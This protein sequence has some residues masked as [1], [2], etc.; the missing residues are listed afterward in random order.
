MVAPKPIVR[1]WISNYGTSGAPDVSMDVKAGE[2]LVVASWNYSTS[3]KAIQ[4][5]TLTGAS[6]SWNVAGT[7]SSCSFSAQFVAEDKTITLG[8][9]A[10]TCTAGVWGTLQI[11]VAFSN[12]THAMHYW[13]DAPYKNPD[14]SSSQP[15]SGGRPMDW[16]SS[17]SSV[18][19]AA[20]GH[21]TM[22]VFAANIWS[23]QT[24]TGAPTFTPD[25]V[26]SL[27]EADWL[28]SWRHTTGAVGYYD[29]TA[30]D[31]SPYGA[32]ANGTASLCPGIALPVFTVEAEEDDPV[33][34]GV[35][36]VDTA[37]SATS[38]DV[39]SV[40]VEAGDWCV[41][42][43][44]C[45]YGSQADMTPDDTW[46]GAYGTTA[47]GGRSGTIA[48][49]RA[50]EAGTVEVTV[51][52]T[53][54]G[55]IAAS[56]AAFRGID[57]LDPSPWE[58]G[59]PTLPDGPC[60][61]L[62][63][64]NAVVTA[65]VASFTPVTTVAVDGEATRSDSSSWTGC[66]IAYVEDGN[67]EAVTVSPA[68]TTSFTA[69][70]VLPIGSGGEDE[71]AE[72][73]Y[74][75]LETGEGV[76]LSLVG[77]WDGVLRPARFVPYGHPTVAGLVGAEFPYRVAHRGG[78]G[79][80]PEHSRRAYT[81]AV[82]AGA[83]A[84]EISCQRTSDGVWIGC[85]DKTL[86]SVGGPSTEV[87]SMTWAEVQEAMA[88]SEYMPCT[89][90]WLLDAY[91][92]SHVIVVDPK[93]S[94]WTYYDEYTAMLAA[95]KSHVVLK[96]SGDGTAL[97]SSWAGDGFTTWAYGYQSWLTDNTT[98]WTSFTTDA[99]K[100]ILSL[101]AP[102][103]SEAWEAAAAVGVPLTAHILASE[104]DV[105]AAFDAGAAGAMVSGWDDL[106]PEF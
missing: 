88:G 31:Y 91:G 44:A 104:A 7:A 28:D 92:A 2:L 24:S 19:G 102:Y 3:N 63:N 95:W 23:A 40:D 6:S 53:T 61:V 76:A 79:T 56:L 87:A 81:Q 45:Q 65:Q 82:W 1:D 22:L 26:T 106:I 55:R 83:H 72:V 89:L 96:F 41:F 52:T 10:G 100:H 73:R 74:P 16:A 94:A 97:F 57:H 75:T 58:D 39:L 77:Y 49:K 21:N 8:P 14:G 51:P 12:V 18:D 50:T 43:A 62:T 30:G 38:G 66:G 48:V 4:L 35:T 99:N 71:A 46:S 33:D 9:T 85:H 54:G 80:W 68:T 32:T 15:A 17:T 20:Y 5:H 105:Q 47:T 64:M 69:W 42:G 37:T 25:G 101:D 67:G 60:I 86:E 36:V 84:L 13:I 59:P 29:L 90:E 11:A 34:E 93:Y 103:D 27:L 78:S 70:A 98:A